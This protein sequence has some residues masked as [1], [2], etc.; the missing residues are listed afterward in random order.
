V[1][2]DELVAEAKA[3]NDPIAKHIVKVKLSTNTIT[4]ALS[5]DLSC[6]SH[7]GL[8]TYILADLHTCLLAYM[9]A[10]LHTYLL[11]YYVCVGQ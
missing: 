11:A 10:C 4:L 3:R 5:Y 7:T 8:L 2:I 9:L 1:W 6:L